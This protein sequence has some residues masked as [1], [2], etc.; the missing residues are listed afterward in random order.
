MRF[1]PEPLNLSD[2]IFIILRD[3]I[4]E[5]TGLFYSSSKQNML[6][7]KLS[8]RVVEHGLDSFLDYYYLL[9]YDLKANEEWQE[10]INT[11]SVPETY[12]WREYDQIQVL[13]EV[14]IPQYLEK[15]YSL[16]YPCQPLRIWSAACST[17]EEPLTIAIALNEAGWFERVPIEIWASDGSSRA[18]DKARMGLYRQY[19]FRSFP[20]ALKRKY[21]VPEADIWRVSPEIHRRIHWSVN[22]LLV[23]AD[24]H[25]LA[26]AHF[27]FCRNVFIYFSDTSIRQTVNFFYERMFK[28]SYLFLSASE[29]LLKLKTN[30][31]LQEIQGAFVY[32][33]NQEGVR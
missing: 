6:A 25:Y 5:R 17:G 23:E 21:F 22:N 27:V 33:K 1:S 2:N 26:Q 29:S 13:V 9:K 11:L 28:P 8:S 3:L 32:V 4:H 19:S 15:F 10:V 24:I 16:S 12:F 7:D 20:D 30:F 14:L 18:I 31:E